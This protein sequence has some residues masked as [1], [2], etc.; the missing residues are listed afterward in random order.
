MS[1][2]NQTRARR[3]VHQGD[4]WFVNYIGHPIHGTAAGL[5]WLDHTTHR[6][7][8]LSL[9]A[10]YWASR[11]K[12]AAYTAIRPDAPT[13]GAREPAAAAKTV[14]VKASPNL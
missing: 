2:E 12:A 4:A 5:I 8:R 7:A 3:S 1:A 6:D 14:I 9:K 11:G 10:G 13:V